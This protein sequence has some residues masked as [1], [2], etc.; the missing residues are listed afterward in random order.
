MQERAGR[1]TG[2]GPSPAAVTRIS[3]RCRAGAWKL[4]GCEVGLWMDCNEQQ[5]LGS[6]GGVGRHRNQVDQKWR[7]CVVFC[8][9][10]GW[11][12]GENVVKPRKRNELENIIAWFLQVVEQLPQGHSSGIQG[13]SKTLLVSDLECRRIKNNDGENYHQRRKTI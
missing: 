7:K 6:P 8:L 11:K 12:S 5:R 2:V 9:C 3:R 10:L 4:Q 13:T 1:I